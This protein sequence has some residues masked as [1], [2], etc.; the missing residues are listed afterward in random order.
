MPYTRALPNRTVHGITQRT[1]SLANP[2]TATLVVVDVPESGPTHKEI[3]QLLR[4]SLLTGVEDDLMRAELV[5]GLLVTHI[6]HTVMRIL[7]LC[8]TM[9]ILHV[10]DFRT[11]PE[12]SVEKL[13]RIGAIGLVTR[14]VATHIPARVAQ[15]IVVAVVV[16]AG[17]TPSDPRFVERKLG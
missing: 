6:T 9:G 5:L 11:L 1:A 13:R 17:E 10:E 2:V 3:V 12:G 16:V 4:T 7:T 14:L 15:R 8:D